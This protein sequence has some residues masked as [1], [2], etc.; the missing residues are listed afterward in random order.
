MT[1]NAFAHGAESDATS[2]FEPTDAGDRDTER[3]SQME[4]SITSQRPARVLLIAPSMQILGGQAVQATRLMDGFSGVAEVQMDFQPMNPNIGPWRQVRYLRTL[5]NG[6]LYFTSIL[7][8]IPRYDIVHIFSASYLSY[9]LW[10]LPTMLLGRLF[11]KRVVLNYRDG[12]ADDHLTNWRT[13]KPS[14][15]LAHRVVSP[16]DY[17]V[18]VFR[19]HGMDASRIYNILNVDQFPFRQ[20][21]SLAP[22]FLTTRI[23]EP[24]YNVDCILRAYQLLQ[25]EY[26]DAFLTIA[27]DGP[28]RSYLE[29]LAHELGLKNYK[30]LGRV[31][32]SHI[33]E[34]YGEADIYLTTPDWDCMPGSLLECHASGLPVIATAVGG[35]PH[36]VEHERNGLLI[37]RNDHEGLAAAA[38]RLLN[39][40]ELVEKLT[41]NGRADCEKYSWDKVR[42]QWLD[43]YSDL[44]KE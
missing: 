44:M 19:K 37:Q 3:E 10:S 7:W 27:H 21:F 30:F 32:H 39:D 15:G 2:D 40:A 16:S 41:I 18:D 31:P 20:R 5:L 43:V 35:I 22:R 29:N 8:R 11:G 25:R 23:L 13:A 33:R 6:L 4:R 24:L 17:V 34:L 42:D 1:T 12:Q 38:L 14:I 9:T 36:I 28:S 26:P